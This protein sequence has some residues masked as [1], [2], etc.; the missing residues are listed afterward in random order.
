MALEEQDMPISFSKGVD[1]KTDPK[2]VMPGKLLTLENCTFQRLDRFQKRPGFGVLASIST[3]N[4]IAAYNNELVA[5]DGFNLYSY[6]KNQGAM[7]LKG[8]KVSC[9]LTVQSII[10]NTY[11][12]T[13]ADSTIHSSG[14]ACYAWNDS[15]GGVRYSIF[16]T[17]TEQSVV[18]NVQVLSTGNNPK[19]MSLGIYMVILICDQSSSPNHLIY[20]AINTAAPTVLPSPVMIGNIGN[21][22][23]FDASF[24]NSNVY[25]VFSDSSSETSACSLSS[26]LSLSSI[27]QVNE[28]SNQLCIFGDPSNN[29]WVGYNTSTPAVR[30]FILDPTLSTL[31]LSPQNVTTSFGGTNG[32]KNISGIYSGSNGSFFIEVDQDSNS[33]DHFVETVTM[34]V[35]GSLGSVAQVLR[36]VGLYSKPFI[37]NSTIYFAVTYDSP[38]Q[39]TY[40]IINSSG[41]VIAKIA[42]SNGGGLSKSG[43]LA[44]S[45]IVSISPETISFAYLFKDK[46]DAIDGNIYT[47]TGVNAGTVVFGGQTQTQ[48]LGKNLIL[49][50]GIVSTYDG[51]SVVEQG[52]NLYP[53]PISIT[54]TYLGGTLSPGSYDYTA[55]YEW[56]DNQGLLNQSAPSVAVQTNTDESQFILGATYSSSGI[57]TYTPNTPNVNLIVR[58][59]KVTGSGV[60]AN[61]FV[62]GVSNTDAMGNGD[63]FLNNATSGSG[64]VVLTFIQNY[65]IALQP[66]GIGSKDYTITGTEEYTPGDTGPGQGVATYAL[67][68]CTIGSNQVQMVVLPPQI[69]IG[70][71]I[72]GVGFYSASNIT[73]T[74]I[75]GNTLT[76]S[77]NAILSYSTC[78]F[79]FD[80]QIHATATNGSAV[81]TSVTGASALT[82][83]QQM[84][85]V[86]GAANFGISYITA[87]NVG[88]STVTM[89][90]VFTASTRTA[91]FQ[92]C[93]MQTNNVYANQTVVPLF[94][95]TIIS[96]SN[97]TAINGYDVTLDQEA[98]AL[99]PI[100]VSI[101]A[102]GSITA[103][104]P[105]LRI[106]D[107][108]T[109]QISLWRTPSDLTSFYRVTSVTSPVLNNKNIDSVT[110][111]DNIPDETLIGNDQLYTNSGEYENISPPASSVLSAFKNRLLAVVAENPLTF[112]YSKQ[113]IPGTPVLFSDLFIE[114]VP[115]YDGGI[116]IP[117]QMDDKLILPK[118]NSFFYMVGSGPAANGT[119]NDFTDPQQIVTDTGVINKFSIAPIPE[120][121]MYQS[122]KGFYLLDRSLGVHYI[123]ADVEAYNG[124]TVTSS[125]LIENANQVRF[126]LGSGVVLKYDYYAHQWE[127]DPGINAASSCA[128]QGF[129]TYLT[130]SGSVLQETTNSFTD[131]GAFIPIKIAT[132]WFNLAQLQGFQRLLELLILGDWKSPHTLLLQVYNDFNENTP[133]QT[134]SIPAL[135]APNG[136]LQYRFF[137]KQ[138]K[139]E[140]MKFVITEQQSGSYGEGLNLSALTL[141]MRIKKGLNKMPASASYG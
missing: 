141:K 55:L 107:K 63:I 81:L 42:P 41:Q 27:K 135:T 113:V 109:V 111:S 11:Q 114:N 140:S 77:D 13:A 66:S 15:Q 95:S 51:A 23:Y 96:S 6:S 80:M 69:K 116:T 119:N 35:T 94:G 85:Q 105:T 16:D 87:I 129:Y 48:V 52:F 4:A 88:A 84:N 131:N 89:N 9:D 74:A 108:T 127:V 118:K 99:D 125:Q 21:T 22:N 24:F 33:Y 76:L 7:N 110:I 61:T 86:W 117:A 78:T 137:F 49:S 115:E 83:G 12:Q 106:T 44:E 20:Y 112:W 126:T 39:P 72:S 14:L 75:S 37:Y 92:F 30:A 10:K 130:A 25:I 32:P 67:G 139:C 132:G 54:R 97:I 3:G 60:P 101:A 134:V 121:L 19:V 136:P 102:S 57:Y 70:W 5:L 47:Q 123:G 64:L 91:F 58:G 100:A 124:Q 68:S 45:N 79:T 104:V 43:I 28:A 36:S 128:F 8:Q 93:P 133:T 29:V 46:L 59:M 103:I 31:V 62:F 90:Q 50:G 98:S 1:T 120:G 138:Q 34:S 122:S 56:T 65:I 17:T 73:V 26:A 2:Q 71:I 53:E 18:T 38:L 40:F 82:I